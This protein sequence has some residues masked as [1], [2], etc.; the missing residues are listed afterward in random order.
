MFF[1]VNK[2]KNH[3]SLPDI[4]ISLGPRQ[5]MD[6][7]RIMKREISENSRHLRAARANGDVE[8]RVKDEPKKQIDIQ[9]TKE[10]NNP[11]KEIEDLRKEIEKLSNTISGSNSGVSKEDLLEI[12]KNLLTPTVVKQVS[13]KEEINENE[14]EEEVEMD[15]ETL[16]KI[17][18]RTMD[19]K[20]EGSNIKSVHYKEENKNNTI[21]NNVDELEGLL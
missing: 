12:L 15:E 4:N 7:D 16:I 10:I 20:V 5:A 13:S 21:L 3:V 9:P 17:N 6:L 18:A 8:I 19:R 14:E 11:I 2:T 1:I